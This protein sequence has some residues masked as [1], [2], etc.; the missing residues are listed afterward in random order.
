[1]LAAVWG[2]VQNGFA[3]FLNVATMVVQRIVR[4]QTISSMV[5]IKL[6]ARR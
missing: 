4:V 2:R 5:E 1:M 6:R 3:T